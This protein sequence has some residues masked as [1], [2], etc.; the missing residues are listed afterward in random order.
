MDHVIY[1]DRFN[2]NVWV[3]LGI[4]AAGLLS[5]LILP[6]PFT[7]LEAWFNL[8]L[9]VTVGL[10]FDHT[11][12]VPPYDYYD[13]GDEAMYQWFDVLSYGMYAPFGY[14]FIYGYERWN[15]RGLWI[16]VYV[17]AWAAFAMGLEWGCQQVGIFHYKNGYKLLYSLP[18]YLIVESL[19]LVLYRVL[20]RRAPASSAG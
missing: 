9:G 12:A 3:V 2:G 1:D 8:L 11:I 17:L 5:F 19:H 14:F 18:V 6:K 16:M 4:M 10:M 7:K 13:V 20:F 15:V